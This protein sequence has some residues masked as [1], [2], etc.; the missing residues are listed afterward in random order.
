[1]ELP[2]L[3][4]SGVYVSVDVMSVCDICAYTSPRL[5]RQSRNLLATSC[6]VAT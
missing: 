1:M 4:R 5:G 2:F 3:L 6:E